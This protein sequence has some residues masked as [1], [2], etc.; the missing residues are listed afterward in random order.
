MSGRGVFVLVLLL[1]ILLLLL[2]FSAQAQLS[3]DRTLIVKMER[4]G[5]WPSLDLPGQVCF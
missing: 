1:L 4:R 3:Y 2:L 5:L